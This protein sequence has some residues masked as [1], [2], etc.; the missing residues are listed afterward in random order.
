MNYV[1]TD[2]E[3]AIIDNYL[4]LKKEFK[5]AEKAHKKVLSS[6][7]SHVIRE[8]APEVGAAGIRVSISDSLDVVYTPPRKYYSLKKAF[9]QEALRLQLPDYY[10][11]RE[12]FESVA[13][14]P[15]KL[16]D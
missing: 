6:I 8:V 2:D 16:E 7:R 3:L 13:I 15:K 4:A 5:K 1:P 14:K 11:E 10:E 9:T 12:G